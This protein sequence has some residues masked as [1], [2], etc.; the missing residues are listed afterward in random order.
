MMSICQLQERRPGERSK[1]ENSS[2]AADR[3]NF[4]S[5]DLHGVSKYSFNENEV[6]DYK[7]GLEV[8]R[9]RI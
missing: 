8:Q 9:G 7:D 2:V 4:T 5:R 3:V 1:G 6:Y